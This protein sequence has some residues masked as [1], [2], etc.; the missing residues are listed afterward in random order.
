MSDRSLRG[1]RLGSQSMESALGFSGFSPST[2]MASWPVL[3]YQTCGTSASMAKV[4]KLEHYRELH[5]L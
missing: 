1:M 3:V 4:T 5:A 2:M